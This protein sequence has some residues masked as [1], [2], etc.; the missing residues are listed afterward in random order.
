MKS[1][2]KLGGEYQII[3]ESADLIILQDT[4]GGILDGPLF[5]I[6]ADRDAVDNPQLIISKLEEKPL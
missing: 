2:P 6:R 3:H 4:N 1:S 5:S